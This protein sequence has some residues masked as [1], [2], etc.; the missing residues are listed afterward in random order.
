MR[1]WPARWGRWGCGSGPGVSEAE[2]YEAFAEQVRAL[3]EGGAEAGADLL[4]IETITSMR[5][6]ELAIRA[7]KREGAG[8]A[9]DRDGD[10]G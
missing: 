3:C 4:V 10:G 9:G 7:A 2:A 8:S 5:E 6:A 1:L